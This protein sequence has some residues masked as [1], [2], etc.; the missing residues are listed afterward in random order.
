MFLFFREL[1][2]RD[3]FKNVNTGPNISCVP[4]LTKISSFYFTPP[5]STAPAERSFSAPRT[6]KKKRIKGVTKCFVENRIL[7]H[8]KIYINKFV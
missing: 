3:M 7:I 5:S 2:I 4:S 1:S 8:V 6:F